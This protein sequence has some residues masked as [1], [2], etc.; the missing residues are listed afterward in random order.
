M[1]D[2]L[3]ISAGLY[4]RPREK[5]RDAVIARR[6]ILIPGHDQQTIVSFGPLHIRIKV[7][8]EPVVTLLDAAIVHV[9]LLI[10]DDDADRGE[11]IK[12]NWERTKRLIDA[13]GDIRE[14]H[15][16]VVL[17][18]IIAGIAHARSDGR[19]A[20]TVAGEGVAGIDQL[21]GEI[22]GAEMMRRGVVGDLLRGAGE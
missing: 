21:T 9:M 15:P 8:A 4:H 2:A 22:G 6:V 16:G 13:A 17:A 11:I 3:G 20:F 14:I 12:I 7:R 18:E 5:S 1:I 10:W 19:Q